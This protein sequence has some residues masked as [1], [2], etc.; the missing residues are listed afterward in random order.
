MYM[1]VFLNAISNRKSLFWPWS[2]PYS[3]PITQPATMPPSQPPHSRRPGSH[4]E[5]PA[6]PGA[7]QRIFDTHPTNDC[8]WN[9]TV[10]TKFDD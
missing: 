1:K 2:N 6:G 8:T 4:T 5:E 9:F 10:V 3:A 7:R